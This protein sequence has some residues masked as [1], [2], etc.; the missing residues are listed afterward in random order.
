LEG[1][2][3]C[4]S[5]DGVH[6]E[7]HKMEYRH[8]PLQQ[9]LSTLTS[10]FS[11]L[12]VKLTEVAHEL[13]ESGLNPADAV[14]EQITACRH[15]FAGVRAGVHD[16]AAAMSISPL[17]KVDEIRSIRSIE[18][19]LALAAAA[20]KERSGYEADHSRTLQLLARVV[21]IQH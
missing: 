14:L 4:D 21:G 15:S 6:Q 9:Q 12:S 18:S 3:L 1:A 20:E 17:P 7:F 16:F 19:L 11:Q 2:G 8:T 13:K 5:V 10:A